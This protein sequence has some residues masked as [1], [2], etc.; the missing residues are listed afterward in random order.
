MSFYSYLAKDI[1]NKI[2]SKYASTN[3]AVL[4]PQV[5]TPGLISYGIESNA[6]FDGAP[7]G[8]EKI[9]GSGDVPKP[10]L[11]P[12]PATLVGLQQARRNCRMEMNN[13]VKE[14]SL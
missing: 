5:E 14:V 6:K 4:Q 1:I 7:T 8:Y 2:A 10:Q 12:Y 3:A 13:I 11:T 9:K